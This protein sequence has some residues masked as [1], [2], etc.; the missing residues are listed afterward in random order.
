MSDQTR[1]PQDDIEV[2][3]HRRLRNDMPG[4]DEG[5]GR[6]L[7]NE[8]PGEDDEPEVEGHRQMKASRQMK[9]Y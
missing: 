1:E 8:M 3:G 5:E 6:R 7:R 2:E 4:G 9:A